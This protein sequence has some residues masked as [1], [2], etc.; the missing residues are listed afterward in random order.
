MAQ[1][2][3]ESSY[4][5]PRAKFCNLRRS[6]SLSGQGAPPY[7]THHTMQLILLAT[8]PLPARWEPHSPRP[9]PV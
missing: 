4:A 2:Q 6:F 1:Q 5:G 7:F 3:V 8:Q 9:A